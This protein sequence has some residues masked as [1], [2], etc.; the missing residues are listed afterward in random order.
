MSVLAAVA[1]PHPPII[2]PSVGK[3]EEKKLEKTT[4]AYREAMRHA[5]SFTPDTVVLISPHAE[6]YADYFHISPDARAAGDLAR[7]GAPEVKIDVC[8]DR[9]YV[10]A[11]SSLAYGDNLPAGTLGA[12]NTR[13]DHASVIPLAFLSAEYTG[14]K[15]VRIGLS[16]LGASEHYRLGR[17]IADVSENLGRKT[18]V[19]AS[20]DLSHRLKEDGP[21]G[22]AQEGPAFDK[23]VVDC[24]RAGDFLT[25]LEIAPDFAEA[26]GECGLRAFQI[27]AGAL[28]KKRVESN[29]MSYE[30]PFGV[31]YCVAFFEPDGEDASRDI[32]R[33]YEKA[34]HEKIRSSRLKEDSFVRLARQTL[35]FWVQSGALMALPDGLPGE[36]TDQQAGA[37]VSIKKNGMLRGCIGTTA[38]TEATLAEEIM[39]N[40][41]SA[42]TADPRFDPV[43][44]DEL[45]NLVY[46]VDVLSAAEPI[47]SERELDV[48]R[49]GV[50]VQSGYRRGLLLPDLEGVDTPQQQIAI[51]KQK[52]GICPDEKTLLY[53]FEVERHT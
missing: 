41:I 44:N 16:G 49:Y 52:A 33:Q 12:K 38:P 48:K 22:Y 13:L 47:A 32:G 34:Q 2:M 29:L 5:A 28:D 51:A 31:G 17:L 50:I 4:L 46:S 14:F 19:I 45:K 21:Y 3:G 26:A 25:L 27:M 1:V 35:E 10:N 30:G 39:R 9:A 7:F 20:G 37:F 43:H 18:L 11:L 23:T 53:R 40:A 24:L 6:M 8:Y 36:L 15:L 42:G